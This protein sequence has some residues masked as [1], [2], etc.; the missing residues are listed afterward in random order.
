[1]SSTEA[2][3]S[4]SRISIV[5]V[6]ISA[7]TEPM[8]AVNDLTASVHASRCGVHFGF[9]LLEEVRICSPF[10]WLERGQPMFVTR[11]SHAS[12]EERDSI[13]PTEIRTSISPSSPVELN[14]TRALV[15]YATEAERQKLAQAH[16]S[17]PLGVLCDPVSFKVAADNIF[18]GV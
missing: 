14:T 18:Y 15:N 6:S 16:V 1:M 2:T 5:V 13:H 17:R 11:S 12:V 9:D 4:T 10:D 7:L 3:P 8:L